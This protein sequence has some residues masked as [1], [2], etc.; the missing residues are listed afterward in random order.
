MG[1]AQEQQQQADTHLPLDDNTAY[2]L[3]YAQRRASV[4]IHMLELLHE[5]FAVTVT[6]RRAFA[7]RIFFA[8]WRER[9]PSLFSEIEV[10]EEGEEIEYGAEGVLV[11]AGGARGR[12]RCMINNCVSLV[13]DILHHPEERHQDQQ[14]QQQQ[15]YR[16]PQTPQ[17]L[18]FRS[19]TLRPTLSLRGG[20]RES[21]APSF[22][23]AP[24]SLADRGRE[25]LLRKEVA[26]LQAEVQSREEVQN[27]LLDILASYERK[28]LD[29]NFADSGEEVWWE[30]GSVS[31]GRKGEEGAGDDFTTIFSGGRSSSRGAGGK[32][33]GREG[34][35]V[36]EGAGGGA[37]L[38]WRV[39]NFCR[40]VQ[41][42]LEE[43][44]AWTEHMERSLVNCVCQSR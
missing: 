43:R 10:G 7:L 4:I 31:G 21:P 5:R 42:A 6:F 24:S 32:G 22:V 18:R 28:N 39:E 8:F 41:Q 1:L 30:E 14:Q 40:V 26:D 44:K 27:V 15:Q 12:A 19:S 13:E 9:F 11:A 36:G 29:L 33:R 35:G 17:Q 23:S 3:T 38:I 25:R 16:P 2:D 20:E 34:R 37:H